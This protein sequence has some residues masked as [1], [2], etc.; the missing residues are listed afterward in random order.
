MDSNHRVLGCSQPPTPLGPQDH[1]LLA[2]CKARTANVSKYLL[3]RVVP[4][5]VEPYDNPYL[6]QRQ[7]NIPSLLPAT[8]C[9][10]GLAFAGLRPF[11]Y[12]VSRLGSCTY[13]GYKIAAKLKPSLQ[14]W[15]RLFTIGEPP[16]RSYPFSW[17]IF[18][19]GDRLEGARYCIRAALNTRFP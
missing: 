8:P 6:L 1:C 2:A 16:P 5:S 13:Y 11:V 4:L 9:L 18:C 14:Q 17:H 3:N 10:L 15:M 7:A 19:Y 12:D